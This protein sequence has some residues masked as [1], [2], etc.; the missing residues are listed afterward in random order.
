MANKSSNHNNEDTPRIGKGELPKTP[1]T[2]SSG[3][4][5]VVALDVGLGTVIATRKKK[6]NR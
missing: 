4:A 3:L 5:G 6:L 1:S 2:N